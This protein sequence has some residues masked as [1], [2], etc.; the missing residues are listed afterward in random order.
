MISEFSAFSVVKS[1]PSASVDSAFLH[2][3]DGG[4]AKDL[5]HAQEK[6]FLE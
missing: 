3:R 6:R 4:R 1:D 5:F 2:P